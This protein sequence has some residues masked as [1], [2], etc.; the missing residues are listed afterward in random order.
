VTKIKNVKDVF[1]I[2]DAHQSNRLKVRQQMLDI[3]PITQSSLSTML[4]YLFGVSCF[5]R[6]FSLRF[7][8]ST[9]DYMFYRCFLFTSL[10]NLF[11][12][13]HSVL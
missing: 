6:K 7:S 12:F 9:A 2:Y 1:Y 8:R 3:T 11:N 5:S 13:S 4:Y 10:F